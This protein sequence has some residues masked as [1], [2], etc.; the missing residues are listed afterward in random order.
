MQHILLS[1]VKITYYTNDR[2]IL[3]EKRKRDPVWKEMIL[4]NF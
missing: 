4:L 1:A 3:T 2:T